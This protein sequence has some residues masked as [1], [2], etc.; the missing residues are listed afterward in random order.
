MTSWKWAIGVL[1]DN[2]NPLA[3]LFIVTTCQRTISQN[4]LSLRYEFLWIFLS[5]V[6]T[7][8]NQGILDLYETRLKINFMRNTGHGRSCGFRVKFETNYLSRSHLTNILWVKLLWF[9]PYFH[10]SLPR[11]KYLCKLV[12]EKNQSGQGTPL[13]SRVLKP[14]GYLIP[15]FSLMKANL[16][17]WFMTGKSFH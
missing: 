4:T 5:E 2:E 1:F 7:P 14:L 15:N 9:L 3:R 17:T 10:G 12:T 6:L 11:N 8:V 16:V 13:K